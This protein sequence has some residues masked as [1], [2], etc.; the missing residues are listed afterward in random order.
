M[1]AV[2][3]QMK[4]PYWYVTTFLNNI[5]VYSESLTYIHLFVII[6]ITMQGIDCVDVF[7]WL[8]TR[9]SDGWRYEYAIPK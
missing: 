1:P 3:G 2:T 6:S 5:N 4:E 9:S 8:L 7:R